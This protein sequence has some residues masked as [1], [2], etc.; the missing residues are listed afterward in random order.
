MISAV[1]RQK[2]QR[3]LLMAGLLGTLVVTPWFNVDPINVPKLF[4]IGVFAFL[5]F[6]VLVPSIRVFFDRKYLLFVVFAALFVLQM[7]FAM[8][9]SSAPWQQLLFGTFGRNTGFIAYL[10]LVLLFLVGVVT[11]SYSLLPKLMYGLLAAGVFNALYGVAQWAGVDPIEWQNPYNSILGTL[12]N[13]NFASSFLG[14]SAIVAFALFFDKGRALWLRVL[15]VVY[16]LG[17]LFLAY[18]SDSI[19][20][21]LVAAVG[22][23]IVIYGLLK[24]FWMRLSFG[25]VTLIGGVFAVLGTLQKGP[26]SGLLYQDSVTYRGDYWRAG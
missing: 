20:G 18:E 12:G 5:A 23:A 10:S 26:L 3:Y 2:A 19:Q 25:V 16:S 9:S 6:G 7:A 15:L 14:M 21:I 11:S 1:V 24:P 13:P 8:F 17:A 4:V 22:F